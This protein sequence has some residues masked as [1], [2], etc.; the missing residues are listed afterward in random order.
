[1]A[2]V[3]ATLTQ[4]R[5]ATKHRAE[6]TAPKPDF[7]TFVSL[8]SEIYQAHRD[9]LIPVQ[10]F[11]PA[12]E[13]YQG[14]GH[15]SLVT[16]EA[17]T[18]SAPSPFAR[19]VVSSFSEGIVIKRPRDIKLGKASSGLISFITELRIRFHPALRS[20]PHI[21]RLR[22]IGWDF[23]DEDATVPRPILLEEFAPQGALDNF[24]KHWNFV[25]M[26]FKSKLEFCRDL[27]GGLRALHSCGV[28]HG[29][30]KPANILV[31]PRPDSRDSF[32]VK[33]TDFGHSAIESDH[34]GILPAFTPQWCAPEATRDDDN[35]QGMTF[36]ELKATDVY[37]YGLVVLSIMIGRSFYLDYKQTE[38]IQRHKQSNTLLQQSIDQVEKEDRECMDS[39]LEVETVSTLLRK[40]IQRDPGLRSLSDCASVIDRFV[41]A[42]FF[43][44]FVYFDPPNQSPPCPGR[45]V[46]EVLAFADT[47]LRRSQQRVA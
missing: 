8:A 14:K 38:D 6:D 46:D 40:T 39:D 42:F 37:S 23:E 30:V 19:G 3:R 44:P 5:G 26:N 17:M 13:T 47:A 4:V 9:H 41:F 25:R 2:G 43:F 18:L 45:C 33:L 12:L 27:A 28:V 31:F 29:D 16:H 20:H 22:G 1:M 32:V 7:I 36:Q 35:A 15:T 34:Q 11:Q 21:A 24:W 10:H